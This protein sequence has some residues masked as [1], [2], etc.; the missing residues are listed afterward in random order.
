MTLLP[1]LVLTAFVCLITLPSHVIRSTETNEGRVQD[2]YSSGPAHPVGR[3]LSSLLWK[4]MKKQKQIKQKPSNNLWAIQT[5]KHFISFARIDSLERI[6]FSQGRPPERTQ[7]KARALVQLR[8]HDFLSVNK[9]QIMSAPFESTE[10]FDT[11]HQLTLV[12]D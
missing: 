5:E 7:G 12:Q 3:P 10:H 8:S 2:L 4:K 9:K 1:V 6:H 11:L